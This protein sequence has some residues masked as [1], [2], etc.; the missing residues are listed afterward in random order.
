MLAQL[1][2]LLQTE[3]KVG[4]LGGPAR[5]VARARGAAGSPLPPWHG[6]GESILSDCERQLPACLRAVGFLRRISV[7]SDQELRFTFLQ[8][9]DSHLQAQLALLGTNDAFAYVC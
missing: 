1:V 8:A 3:L 7:L 2:A 9:R 6:G 4:L 5:P